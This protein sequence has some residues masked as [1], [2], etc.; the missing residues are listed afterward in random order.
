[1]SL[2]DGFYLKMSATQH[3]PT[4]EE[5]SRISYVGLSN[6]GMAYNGEFLTVDISESPKNVDESTLSDFL[7]ESVLEMYYLSQ[8]DVQTV[9]RRLSTRGSRIDSMLHAALSYHSTHGL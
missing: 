2:R 7:E 1:M 5:I 9:L 8:A 3:L 4:M 6:A